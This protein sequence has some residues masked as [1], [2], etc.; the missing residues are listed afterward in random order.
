MPSRRRPAAATALVV[1]A[2]VAAC[3][4]RSTP[5]HR[6]LRGARLEVLGS[7]S[8][9]EQARFTAVLTA[10]A[11]STGASVRYTHAPD[12]LPTVLDE[13]LARRDPPDL[14]VLPQPGVLVRYARAGDLVALDAA[15]ARVVRQRYSSVWRSL[16]TVHGRQYGVWFKA[17][18]KSLIWYDV[19]SFERAG[20]VPP[21]DLAGLLRV[22]RTLY[23]DGTTPWS[24]GAGAGDGWTLTD[25][26][27]NLYLRQAGPAL[28]DRLTAHTIPWT[29]PS[30]TRALELMRRLL[31]PQFLLGGVPGSLRRGFEDSVISAFTRPARAAM[32]SEGDF[33]AAVVTTRTRDRLTSDVD[34]FTFPGSYRGLPVVVGGGDVVVQMRASAAGR[35]LMRYLA[36]PEAAAVWARAG[37][38]VSANLDLDLAVYPDPISRAVARSLVEAGDGFR[39]DLSD[40]Q[41]A[42][43]GAAPTSGMQGALRRFLAGL[44]VTRTQQLLEAAASAAEGK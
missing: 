19:A 18:D 29:D 16:A 43:F 39:F 10:F 12:Y 5:T 6:D 37:G 21:T 24:I 38:F 2:L 36:S 34:T 25:V 40:Q 32:V 33:V 9:V 17:A 15:T 23:R 22:V 30:V 26:F 1:L 11:R 8:N 35:Q 14:A 13:R 41:P 27:E 4:P 44:D 20:V 28:Y 31:A 3:G 7:W 42:Q